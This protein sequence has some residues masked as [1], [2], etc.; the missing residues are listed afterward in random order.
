MK[1]NCT[2]INDKL[3]MIYAQN[4]DLAIKIDA[5]GGFISQDDVEALIKVER[6]MPVMVRCGG[7]R[8]TTAIQNLNHFSNII[9]K[10][11]SDYIRDVSLPVGY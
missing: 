1:F 7:G 8:F 10:E 11:G 9:E 4:R 2:H 5:Q 3:Q 6:L